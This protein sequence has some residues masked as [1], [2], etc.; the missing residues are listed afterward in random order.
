MLAAA[1][2][3]LPMVFRHIG[4]PSGRLSI[5]LL[6]KA[7][8]LLPAIAFSM[9]W[10]LSWRPFTQYPTKFTA[11]DVAI[12][13]CVVVLGFLWFHSTPSAALTHVSRA[14]IIFG[15]PLALIE[16]LLFRG[17]ILSQLR[18]W[19]P[20]WA[21]ILLQSVLF[22]IFHVPRFAV[23]HSGLPLRYLSF[24][25]VAGLAWG[26]VALRTKSVWPSTVGHWLNNLFLSP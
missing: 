23:F 20:A 12:L 4:S 3:V 26:A 7:A 25:F 15:L 24:I 17:F 2:T 9:G 10:N 6:F 8:I 11:W 1:N 19:L 21:A 5:E 22:V 13:A 16:E 14:R 18:R